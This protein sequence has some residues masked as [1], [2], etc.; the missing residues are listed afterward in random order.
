MNQP[1]IKFDK[2]LKLKKDVISKLDEAQMQKIAGGGVVAACSTDGP[3]CSCS[4]KSC[5]LE[6]PSA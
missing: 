3:A 6:L 1:K 2:E 5:N 4:K